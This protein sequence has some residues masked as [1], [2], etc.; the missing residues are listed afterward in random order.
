MPSPL[1]Q[2]MMKAG[3]IP[4]ED[5]PSIF[6]GKFD[7]EVSKDTIELSNPDTTSF[8]AFAVA[9]AKV[10]L[11]GTIARRNCTI[12]N[13]GA[14]YCY[15]YGNG[16]TDWLKRIDADENVPATLHIDNENRNVDITIQ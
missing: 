16:V 2:A 11:C 14:Y 4:L 13:F 12:S 10:G 15:S 5:K 3:K 7:L 6:E 9:L 1:V 8:C